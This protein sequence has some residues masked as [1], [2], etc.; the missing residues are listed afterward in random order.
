MSRTVLIAVSLLLLLICG[1]ARAD[2]GTLTPY[3]DSEPQAAE[4]LTLSDL[5][6]RLTLDHG[7]ARVEMMQIYASH[8][9]RTLEGRYR[10]IIPEWA[11]ISG[12]AVWDDLVR[13]PGVIL[14]KTKAR[15]LFD[16]I[17]RAAIDPGLMGGED[18]TSVVN[19]FTVQVAPIA[20]YGT[21]R[22]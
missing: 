8:D 3:F 13:I 5:E 12:F 22:L 10:L 17:V 2:T 4:Q 15:R 19:E 20:P 6:I 9:D 21:K 1:V 7:L 16:E 18:E 14:E 11:D